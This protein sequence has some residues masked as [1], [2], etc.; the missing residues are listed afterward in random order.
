MAPPAAGGLTAGSGSVVIDSN[1]IQG[2]QAGAGD[3]G[4]IRL[5]F[6]NG[7]DVVGSESLPSAWNRVDIVNN[8]IVNN[9]AGLAGG[10]ISMQDAA[11]P[12]IINNTI[13][14]NDSTATAGLAFESVGGV[15]PSESTPQP[16]GVVSR[17]HSPDLAAL[18]AGLLLAGP[19]EPEFY[20]GFSNPQFVNN[21][22]WHNRSFYFAIDVAT[23]TGTILPDVATTPP[24]YWDLAVL[25][26][27]T[28]DLD[29][30]FSLLTDA[31]GYHT[32]NISEVTSAADPA[33]LAEYV[34]GGLGFIFGQPE[35]NT[36]FDVAA[37]VDEGGNFIDLRFSPLTRYNDPNPHPTPGDSNPGAL[38]GDY[39]ISGTS[40]ALDI[41]DAAAFTPPGF[42][43][44][45]DVDIDNEARPFAVTGVDIGAD[46]NVTG[47]AGLLNVCSADDN[48][49][50]DVDGADLAAAGVTPADAAS[51]FGRIDCFQQQ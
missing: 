12:N 42:D 19:A 27:G 41:G 30:R 44:L 37:A 10:G 47:G 1:V 8:M 48:Q 38:F 36:N 13:A 7:Q 35:A 18:M 43:A 4:G 24:S 40:S 28:G 46:E 16:A 14:N 17:A 31:T 34:N 51:D 32:S 29:P 21:I 9:A 23:N 15:P 6:I 39:H 25:P 45:L 50:G 5:S 11:R 49:D 3:A 20:Q 22:I 33:F 26:A 2:N